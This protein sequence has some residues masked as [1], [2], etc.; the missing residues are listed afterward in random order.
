MTMDAAMN[1]AQ[2]DHVALEI[3]LEFHDGQLPSETGHMT[4]LDDSAHFLR[5]V[6]SCGAGWGG[7]TG[8]YVW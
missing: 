4:S 8:D 1:V 7:V 2:V 6:P 5:Y 3:H